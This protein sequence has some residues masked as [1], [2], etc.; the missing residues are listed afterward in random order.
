[1]LKHDNVAVVV[2]VMPILHPVLLGRFH[3][4]CCFT[5]ILDTLIFSHFYP[6]SVRGFSCCT[7]FIP[8]SH[9]FHP[10]VSTSS[11]SHQV[12]QPFMMTHTHQAHSNSLLCQWLSYSVTLNH[13]SRVDD[14]TCVFWL[15][16]AFIFKYLRCAA[17]GHCDQKSWSE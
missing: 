6:F 9:P 8:S 16:Y 2:A 3:P 14:W 7:S 11:V 4:C 12:S 13:I 5:G 1:M 15:K 10:S 17:M